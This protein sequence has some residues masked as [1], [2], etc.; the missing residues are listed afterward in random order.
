MTS[1]PDNSVHL[2][3]DIVL[4]TEVN[5]TPHVLLTEV[6]DTPHVL[7]IRRSD[8]SD[9]YPGY[10]ALPGGYVDAGERIEDAARRELAEETAVTAPAVLHQVGIYDNPDR[11]PRW[12]VVSVAYMAV[13]PELVTATAGDDAHDAAWTRVRGL[14]GPDGLCLAFDHN[15]VLADAMARAFD[16]GTEQ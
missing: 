4:L 2:T 9:A 7:L 15:E 11:D 14:T 5:D 3:V 16:R 1:Q 8:T 10:W 6:N 13:L 12:R